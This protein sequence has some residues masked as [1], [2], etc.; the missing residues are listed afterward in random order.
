MLPLQYEIVS[1]NMCRSKKVNDLA[2]VMTQSV[3]AI[4]KF[5][6]NLVFFS[7]VFI[8][9]FY[10]FIKSEVRQLYEEYFE[11]YCQLKSWQFGNCRDRAA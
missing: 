10:D 5:N 4:K 6:K 8:I 2:C 1:K 3:F 9:V 7:F 11:E